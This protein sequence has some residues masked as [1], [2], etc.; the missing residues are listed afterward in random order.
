[1]EQ[2]FNCRLCNAH[3]IRKTNHI[4]HVP[5]KGEWKKFPIDKFKSGWFLLQQQNYL[6]Q[7]KPTRIGDRFFSSLRH[8]ATNGLNNTKGGY[9]WC[10]DVQKYSTAFHF[11]VKW[12]KRKCENRLMAKTF[13]CTTRL[14][15]LRNR[16]IT[17]RKSEFVP[18]WISIRRWRHAVDSTDHEFPNHV[19]ID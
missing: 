15:L 10:R 9:L 2:G 18:N 5:V 6:R 3:Y 12:R 17:L 1:M 8:R 14:L 11:Q 13:D 7:Q 16:S 4:F 19:F